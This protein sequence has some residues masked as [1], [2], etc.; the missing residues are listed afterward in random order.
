MILN[1]QKSAI[2]FKLYMCLTIDFYCMKSQ[3]RFTEDFTN[4]APAKSL[5]QHESKQIQGLPIVPA[6][7]AV[8]SATRDHYNAKKGRK[9]SHPD[10]LIFLR[11]QVR[12]LTD[13]VS[14]VEALRDKVHVN[15]LEEK[16]ENITSETNSTGM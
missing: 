7:M 2:D 12:L 10:E 16:L 3:A 8:E 13:R 14:L 9:M 15:E 5:L 4:H 6:R 1:L 11:E